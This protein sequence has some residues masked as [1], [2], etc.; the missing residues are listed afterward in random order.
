MIDAT[1][2][3]AATHPI[4]QGQLPPHPH[5][6]TSEYPHPEHLLDV[7]FLHHHPKVMSHSPIFTAHHILGIHHQVARVFLL[8]CATDGLEVD[9]FVGVLGQRV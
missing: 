6:I 2:P 5:V 7:T 9:E 3:R 8:H 1:R 4:A